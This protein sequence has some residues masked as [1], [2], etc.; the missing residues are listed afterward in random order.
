MI[1]QQTFLEIPLPLFMVHHPYQHSALIMFS[2]LWPHCQSC[3]FSFFLELNQPSTHSSSDSVQRL[4]F[5]K[6]DCF[7]MFEL[8]SASF[9]S[10]SFSFL[11]CSTSGQADKKAQDRSLTIIGVSGDHKPGSVLWNLELFSW[12]HSLHQARILP[13]FLKP[14]FFF[15]FFNQFRRVAL[16]SGSLT[17]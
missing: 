3:N 12:P 1:N 11:F 10:H 17:M 4:S 15:F 6:K 7:W 16:L 2:F 8:N 14:F 9:K 5:C 13:G